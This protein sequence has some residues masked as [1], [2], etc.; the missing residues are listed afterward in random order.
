MLKPES[1]AKVNDIAS[2][3]RLSLEKSGYRVMTADPRAFWMKFQSV[4]REDWTGQ[5]LD[6]TTW[7]DEIS[8]I[9]WILSAL[10]G[11]TGVLITIL[12]GIIVI[13]IM[14]T[15]WIAIRERTREIGTL[16]AIGMQRGA[17]LW[18]FLLESLMLG[19]GGTIAG[20]A[21]GAIVAGALNSAHIHVGTGMQFILM[22]DHL[23]LAVH[24]SLLVSSVVL[25]T[26]VTGIAALY[27]SLR[28]ARLR[29]VVAMQHFG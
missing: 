29:P 18:M 16:R 1:V 14:N 3:L 7:E 28:A 4:S 12:L 19:L 17:V 11:L 8:F 5:K 20:A 15:M 23:H 25:I 27:P 24:G 2:R 26:I 13:G 6:V 21:L 22:S 9:T 10:K